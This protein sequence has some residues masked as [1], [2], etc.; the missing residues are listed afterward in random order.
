MAVDM[1]VDVGQLIKG[2]FSKKEK[3]E[4][5]AKNPPNP[6]AKTAIGVVGVIVII[7]A[8]VYFIYLPTQADLKVKN[9]KISQI[10]MLK[11]EIEDLTTNIEEAEKVLAVAQKEYERRTTLFHTDKELEDLYGQISLL[12]MQNK[13]MITKIQKGIERPVFTGESCSNGMTDENEFEE[14]EQFTDDEMSVQLQK[15]GYYEFVVNLEL[16]GNYNQFTRFRS[17]LAELKKIININ[18]ETITVPESGSG[19]DVKVRSSIATYRLPKNESEECSDP[20]QELGEEEY[21]S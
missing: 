17:G 21:D 8:Y 2:L 18:N 3:A 16:S 5:G 9:E 14:D 6:H 1:N 19:G 12:A 10:E 11:Y 13:L 15:V 4:G 7:A 20:D